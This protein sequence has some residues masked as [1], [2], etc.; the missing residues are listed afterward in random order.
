[1]DETMIRRWNEVVGK[2]DTVIHLGDFAFGPKEKAREYLNGLY[3]KVKVLIRGTHDRGFPASMEMGWDLCCKQMVLHNFGRDILL[4]HEPPQKRPDGIGLVICGHTH[5][6][7][8]EFW[9]RNVCVENT[10]YYP[11]S[12]NDVIKMKKGKNNNGKQ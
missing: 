7:A 1:M 3:G 12:L 9:M 10:N 2:E 6:P 8:T 4:V 5:R 11:I